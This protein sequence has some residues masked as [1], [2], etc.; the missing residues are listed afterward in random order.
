M[1]TELENLARKIVQ[2]ALD[3]VS[4]SYIIDEY[5]NEEL[6]FDEED[7][8]IEENLSAVKDIINSTELIFP[9]EE[10]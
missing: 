1:K 6:L 4:S 3:K 10:I 5:P 2:D 8:L 7:R 9:E